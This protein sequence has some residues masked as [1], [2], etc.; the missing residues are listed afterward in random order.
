M[1]LTTTSGMTNPA[2]LTRACLGMLSLCALLLSACGDNVTPALKDFTFDGQAPDSSVVM[3]FGISFDDPDGDLGDGRLETFIN[4]RATSVGA[5]P[6]RQLFL[7]EALPPD[8][9]VGRLHFV[10]ELSL[11]SQTLPESGSTFDVGVRAV[12]AA[13]HTS[14]MLEQRVK[15]TY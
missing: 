13:S 15:I 6:M 4:G 1:S 8:T 2:R 5:L 9:T 10:L 11:T 12:D 7:D 3:L 14:G